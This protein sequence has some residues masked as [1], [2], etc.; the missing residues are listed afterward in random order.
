MPRQ[1]GSA[2]RRL[3]GDPGGDARERDE[4]RSL[5]LDEP[6]APLPREGGWAATI[7]ND[8][9]PLPGAELKAYAYCK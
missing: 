2:L 8:V 7:H 3:Q 5:S 1:L 6:H 9:G 4:H